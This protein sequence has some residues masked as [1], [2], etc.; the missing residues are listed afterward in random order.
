MLFRSDTP[1]FTEIRIHDSGKGFSKEDLPRLFD[2]FY[3]GKSTQTAG[4]GIGLS[5]CK[6]I[7]TRHGGTVTAKNHPQGGAVF[8]LRFPKTFLERA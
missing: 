1:I 8:C 4:Y 6:T 5:L 2:R 3:R 7:V